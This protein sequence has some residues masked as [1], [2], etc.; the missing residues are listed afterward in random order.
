MC[1]CNCPTS[2]ESPNIAPLLQ[3]P[4]H[5]AVLNTTVW[6]RRAAGTCDT[7]STSTCKHIK[8]L[9]SLCEH[10]EICNNW[11]K[12]RV[13][14]ESL[15][16]K[17]DV[18]A[19]HHSQF[20]TIRDYMGIPEEH[21]VPLRATQ[22]LKCKGQQIPRG[23]MSCWGLSFLSLGVTRWQRRFP[24]LDA[25]QAA[26]RQMI[27]RCSALLRQGTQQRSLTLVPDCIEMNGRRMEIQTKTQHVYVIGLLMPQENERE[28]V[29]DGFFNRHVVPFLIFVISGGVSSPEVVQSRHVRLKCVSTCVSHCVQYN[30]HHSPPPKQGTNTQQFVFMALY[31]ALE[32]R[33][34]VWR[35]NHFH[36]PLSTRRLTKHT[37]C[38]FLQPCKHFL[39]PDWT[40]AFI[41]R[42]S[43]P[44]FWTWPPRLVW[45]FS[46]TGG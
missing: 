19:K 41:R 35:Q 2:K 12:I 42:P 15:I 33:S 29:S 32:G 16:F 45:K 39:V 10:T 38:I 27:D 6:A 28:Q 17:S 40:N 14:C 20:I 24:A 21:S 43:A 31:Q 44:A 5:P 23:I 26:P 22:I 11:S 36:Y 3:A 46:L 9:L 30:R 4:N 13:C 37:G 18:E 8:L 7:H 25:W 1:S 34:G